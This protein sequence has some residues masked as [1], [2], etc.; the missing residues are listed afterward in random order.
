MTTNDN[1]NYATITPPAR[2]DPDSFATHREREPP[3]P[4][5]DTTSRKAKAL[6]LDARV[7][8]ARPVIES[9]PEAMQATPGDSAV[10]LLISARK[11]RGKTSGVQAL[12]T[13]EDLCPRAIRHNDKLVVQKALENDQEALENTA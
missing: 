8:H 12:R 5:H 1:S 10:V 13:N 11:I 6:K 4:G 3:D 7:E 2:N 9:Q